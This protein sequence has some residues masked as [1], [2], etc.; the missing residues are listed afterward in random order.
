VAPERTKQFGLG[1]TTAREMISLI[2]LIQAGKIASPAACQE[3]LGHMKKCD[4]KDKFTRFLPPGVV[5]AHK[6]GSVNAA[7]TDAGI[8]YLKQ[9]PVAICVLTAQNEDKTWK[10]DNAG[11][12]LCAKVAKEV[13]DYYQSK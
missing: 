9:G 13:Y 3:M 11:N 12:L 6:T 2:E 4:D 5:V 8:L 1:S 7:R 10:P